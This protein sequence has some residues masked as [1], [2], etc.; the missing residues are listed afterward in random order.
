MIS[1]IA[2]MDRNRNIGLNGDM[3]WGNSMKADLT[4]F[5]ELTTGKAV[6]MGRKTFESLPCYPY[7]L[8]NRHNVILSRD[9]ALAMDV[10]AKK[11]LELDPKYGSTIV[12][13]STDEFF[14]L[15]KLS[16]IEEFFVIGG[17]QIYEQFMPYADRVYLTKIHA[18]YEGD[19]HFPGMPGKWNVLSKEVF[20]KDENNRHGHS[21]TV[22][23]R[24]RA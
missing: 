2:A 21:F 13:P 5:K 8:P 16:T 10:R 15:A 11:M 24:V 23:E 19:T 18:Y 14:Q 1:I 9:P 3:P 20:E 4:R 22:F 6:I 7:P 17:A 12:L